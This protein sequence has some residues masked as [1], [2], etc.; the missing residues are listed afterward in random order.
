MQLTEKE[1]KKIAH[2][3]RIRLD[4]KEVAH[5]QQELSGIMEWIEMLQEVDTSGVP[6]MASTTHSQLQRRKDEITD[7]GYRDDVLANAPSSEYGCF[8]VPKVIE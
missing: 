7:A 1:I 4:E 6:E 2:L 3:S 8:L 5:F